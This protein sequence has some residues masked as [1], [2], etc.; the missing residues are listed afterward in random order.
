MSVLP[1]VV[2]CA[3]PRE[4]AT[5]AATEQVRT[6]AYGTRDLLQDLVSDPDAPRGQALLD[7]VLYHFPGG[8]DVITF[9]KQVGPD[10]TL[11]LRTAFHTRRQ[12]GGGL[13]YD[14]VVARLCV[15]FTAAPGPPA[16]VNVRDTDCAATL[17]RATGNSGNV[18]LTV[19][20]DD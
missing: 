19:T 15:E 7:H 12:Y 4:D 14:D 11:T 5:D 3:S 16:V 6:S 13:S 9:T 18:D 1:T 17:P 2:A 20:R 8:E 10:G